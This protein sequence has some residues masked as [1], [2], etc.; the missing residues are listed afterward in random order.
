MWQDRANV[1]EIKKMNFPSAFLLSRFE[2]GHGCIY[3]AQC[4]Q[5]SV[6][7]SLLSSLFCAVMQRETSPDSAARDQA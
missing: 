3:R 1:K 6:T 5:S 4:T 2:R 7:S